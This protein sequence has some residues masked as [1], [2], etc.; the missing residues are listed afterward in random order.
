MSRSIDVTVDVTEAAGLGEPL[1]TRAT[2]TLPDP[3][4]IGTPPV[5]CFGFPGGGYSRQ[6][7]TFAM[8][9]GSDGGPVGG[10]AGWHARRGW[11]FVSCDHLDVGESSAPSDPERLTFGVVAAANAATVAHVG[12]ALADGTLTD[13]YPPVGDAVLLGIGQSMGGCFTIVQQGLLGT[14][15]G[16]GVLGFSA[17]QTALVFP[18]D[19]EVGDDVF[20]PRADGLPITTWGF[21]Y[22]DEPPDMVAEDMR[23]YPTRGGRVPVWGSATMPP[24]AVQMLEPGCVATEAAAIRVPVFVGVGERDVCPDPHSEPRAY[25]QSPDITV[26]VCPRMSHM[27]NFASTR[28]QFWARLH[29]WGEGIAHG[30]T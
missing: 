13:G 27:H 20:A 22:D 8:P 24:C 5:V 30:I 14:Y 17:L 15:A 19:T 23:D 7:F 18:P 16:I 29:A 3:A 25:E 6:Y 12:A 26:F 4:T 1:H 2:V 9:D 21:H 10:Q 28:E 11:I